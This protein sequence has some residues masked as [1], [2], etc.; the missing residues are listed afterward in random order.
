MAAF[1]ARGP[2]GRGARGLAGP[3][4]RR[5]PREERGAGQAKRAAREEKG[6]AAR[7]GFKSSNIFQMRLSSNL[8][9]IQN[10]QGHNRS[11]DI[12]TKLRLS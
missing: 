9:E 5:R 11:K 2:S 3:R 1:G 10:V 12:H 8:R 6:K 7:L 4:G